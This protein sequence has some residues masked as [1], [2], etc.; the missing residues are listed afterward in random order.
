M[1]STSFAA[2]IS[3]L[4]RRHRDLIQELLQTRS[5]LRGSFT[6][7]STSCGKS[8]CWC[9][10]SAHGHPH[11]RLTWSQ[12]GQLITRKVPPE[13]IDR[14]RELTGCYRK[15]R[16]QRREL[17]ALEQRIQ[18]ALDNYENG[19]INQASKPLSFLASAPKMSVR[20][21]RKRQ[22]GGRTSDRNT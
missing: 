16:S 14:V 2:R 3:G 12:D 9:A 18:K 19:L 22:N 10:G 6:Q 15:F 8:N 11:A 7:V 21:R 1:S 17:L 5:I 13:A 4:V 20:T